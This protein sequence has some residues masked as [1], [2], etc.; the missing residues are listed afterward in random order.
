MNNVKYINVY[1]TGQVKNPGR[2]PY[3]DELT[4]LKVLALAGGLTDKA[5]KC[6]ADRIHVKRQNGTNGKEAESKTVA[7][8]DLILPD[9]VIQVPDCQTIDVTGDV[10][11]QA[12]YNY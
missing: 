9:D 2:Y 6:S 10:E 3:E 11:R 1:I 7:L 5:A 4:V 12:A 8:D